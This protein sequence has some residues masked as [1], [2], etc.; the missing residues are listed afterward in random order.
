MNTMNPFQGFT[1]DFL[2]VL[3]TVP[4]SN[5]NKMYVD[6]GNAQFVYPIQSQP[7]SLPVAE[8]YYANA[9]HGVIKTNYNYKELNR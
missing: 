2:A 8:G 1:E 9:Q 6:P 7:Q 5:P 3:T 4:P